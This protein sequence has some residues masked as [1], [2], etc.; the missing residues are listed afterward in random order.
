MLLFIGI[1]VGWFELLGHH[2]VGGAVYTLG[3][4]GVKYVEQQSLHLTLVTAGHAAHLFARQGQEAS[5]ASPYA[6]CAY[7]QVAQFLIVG[8]HIDN[9]YKNMLIR[10][11]CK[12]R[13]KSSDF[14]FTMVSN[15]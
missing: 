3:F 8:I 12:L 6:A 5:H 7:N 2:A 11:L 14:L 4:A 9:Y 13:H 15:G 1:R 10:Q